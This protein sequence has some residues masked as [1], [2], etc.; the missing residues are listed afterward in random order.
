MLHD[1][2]PLQEGERKQA[3]ALAPGWLA[4]PVLSPTLGASAVAALM[5][6]KG[7]REHVH[8]RAGA[9][10]RLESSAKKLSE[11]FTLWCSEY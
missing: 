11:F 1:G 9:D 10:V 2:C 5:V 3:L 4:L 6:R 8:I 7:A